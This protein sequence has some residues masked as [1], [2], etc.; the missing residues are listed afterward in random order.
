MQI[1]TKEN[2]ALFK[3]DGKLFESLVEE[4]LHA[5]YPDANFKHTS[6]TR[7]GGKDFEGSF[8][9][10]DSGLKTW[11]EC[12]YH[13]DSLPIEDVS[14]TL[15]MAYVESAHAILFFSY[16][17]VNSEF[18]KYIDLYQN[19]SNKEIKIYD[20]LA[21]EELILKN[22]DKI[23]FKKFFGNFTTDEIVESYGMTYKYWVHS[24]NQTK[25]LHI[26]L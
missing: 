7:D 18:Q 12:K 11:A 13:K 26:N 5:I 20:D 21:L 17:P 25:S 6:W 15:F 4:L 2:W 9:F 16:S 19:K 22:K 23:N 14:M 1:L 10:F 3:E 24:K 8:S